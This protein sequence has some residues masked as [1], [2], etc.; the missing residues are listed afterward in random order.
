VQIGD[1]VRFSAHPAYVLLGVVVG[2]DHE[3]EGVLCFIEGKNTWF[4]TNQVEVI[5][6]SR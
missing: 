5:N 1:L 2:F 4:R 3:A 6:A